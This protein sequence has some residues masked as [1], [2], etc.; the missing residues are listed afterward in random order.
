MARETIRYTPEV[1]TPDGRSV[2]ERTEACRALQ[3]VR[4]DCL[5]DFAME[6]LTRLR[7]RPAASRRSARY[8]QKQRAGL[9]A[10]S[11]PSRRPSGS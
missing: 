4:A 10:E 11:G 7:A 1:Q 2:A 5:D 6:E 9:P 8:L 3:G